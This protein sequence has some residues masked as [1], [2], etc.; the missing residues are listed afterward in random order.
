MLFFIFILF[1]FKLVHFTSSGDYEFIIKH[2]SQMM[3]PCLEI[4]WIVVQKI[5]SVLNSDGYTQ[6]KILL[7][8]KFLFI[9]LFT[10]MF[11][12]YYYKILEFTLS[13]QAPLVFILNLLSFHNYI[14]IYMCTCRKIYHKWKGVTFHVGLWHKLWIFPPPGLS[15]KLTSLKPW[16]RI[17]I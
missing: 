3:R 13:N 6:K 1:N 2:Y 9:I 11:L 5:F 7:F 10:T 8:V 16:F 14:Y 12:P 17:S 4:N 15:F